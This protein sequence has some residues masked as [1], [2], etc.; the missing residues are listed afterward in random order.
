M[1]M[2][3]IIASLALVLPALAAQTANAQ[4]LS[5]MASLACE[6]TL[7]LSTGQPPH[8]CTPSLNKYFSIVFTKPWKTLQ[9]RKNFL[10][11][12]P[13]VQE[14]DAQSKAEQSITQSEREEAAKPHSADTDGG[15]A[16]PGT[17]S[18]QPPKE[19]IQAALDSLMPVYNTQSQQSVAARQVLESCVAQQGTVEAGHC[20]AEKA[21]F[22]AKR[23]PAI[24]LRTEITRLET[25]LANSAQ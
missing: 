21:D 5:A 3:R 8:E 17:Q 9:A 10:K 24:T 11:L 6:A 22:D 19:Q 18:G 12:C 2:K 23:V 14:A 25:L 13:D 4:D 20:Q 16:E 15:D 1:K 7:C